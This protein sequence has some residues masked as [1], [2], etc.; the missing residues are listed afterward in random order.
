[1][2]RSRGGADVQV[3]RRQTSNA[4]A[5]LPA[6]P[7]TRATAEG[8]GVPP[9]RSGALQVGN[10]AQTGDDRRQ[11]PSAKRW[12]CMGGEAR[13]ARG[14]LRTAGTWLHP[15]GAFQL[16]RAQLPPT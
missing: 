9:P 10:S 16:R 11:T 12:A 13:A 14:E 7:A 3:N 4:P 2:R 5:V 15:Q 6:P 8:H 1:M